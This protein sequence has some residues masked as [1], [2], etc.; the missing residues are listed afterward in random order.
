VNAQGVIDQMETDAF[1]APLAA[2]RPPARFTGKP[3]DED[4]GAY[5]FPFRNYRPDEARWMTPDPSGFPDGVNNHVYAPMPIIEADPL[6]LD[7]IALW[8][9]GEPHADGTDINDSGQAYGN[10]E[11]LLSSELLSLSTQGY[12][13]NNNS[14][15]QYRLMGAAPGCND[16]LAFDTATDVSQIGTYLNTLVNSNDSNTTDVEIWFASHGHYEPKHFH[17]GDYEDY[18]IGG[19]WFHTTQDLSDAIMTALEDG[20]GSNFEGSLT[21]GHI[22][23]CG[24]G[25]EY[26]KSH[27]D[28]HSEIEVR[29]HWKP[30]TKDYLSYE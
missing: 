16:Q 10:Q 13:A 6:G 17:G 9:W 4:M 12:L 23:A 24:L 18:L 14:P 3:Y 22:S 5:I 28:I 21:I 2:G 7:K 8:I 27:S 11:A 15:G 1:G 19:K 30:E 26:G 29:D 25:N 20:V